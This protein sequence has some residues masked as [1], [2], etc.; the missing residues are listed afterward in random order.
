MLNQK[1]Y[2]DRGLNVSKGRDCI[3]RLFNNTCKT[4]FCSGHIEM[5]DHP[6]MFIHQR[7]PVLYLSQPYSFCSF[8]DDLDRVVNLVEGSPLVVAINAVPQTWTD[9]VN[10]IAVYRPEYA[11]IIRPSK[12]FTF[13]PHSPYRHR[14]EEELLRQLIYHSV[15]M[16][17]AAKLI[18]DEWIIQLDRDT[19]E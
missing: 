10:T 1:W 2:A 4:A 16:S 5:E 6:Q 17:D 8:V 7:Q 13:S 12:D 18:A 9:S 15:D 11:A 3:M 19:E 14:N